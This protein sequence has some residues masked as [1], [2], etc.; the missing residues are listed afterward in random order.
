M[1]PPAFSGDPRTIWLSEAVADRRME[2]ID[3]FSFD[4]RAGRRWPA[5]AGSTIDGASI[6]RPLWTTVGSPYTGD[7]RRASI[8]HDVACVEAGDDF[9]RRL[10]ADKMFFEA[11][12]AGGCSVFEATA[13]FVG[14]RIGAW[15]SGASALETTAAAPSDVRLQ[16]DP[17]DRQVEED[18]R[19]ACELVLSQGESDDPDV[20][21]ART[22]AAIGRIAGMRVVAAESALRFAAAERAPD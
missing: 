20:I 11:C 9:Q 5:P 2:L 7:Y 17:L 12:R 1:P 18:Y 21:A 19:L 15:A 13:L 3:D 10:A 4:D 14:V 8:V 22:D 6:P 16:R